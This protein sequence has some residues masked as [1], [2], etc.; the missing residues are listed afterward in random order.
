MKTKISKVFSC[1][2][3][4]LGVFV[5]L[6]L[7]AFMN[8]R[9][10]YKIGEFTR[11]YYLVD[12]SMGKA[13]RLLVGSIVRLLT[14]NP[15]S[16]WIKNFALTVFFV[17]IFF[18]A[19][20]IG[21]AIRKTDESLRT[22]VYIFAMFF[23]SGSF[24]MYNYSQFVGMLDIYMFIFAVLAAVCACNKYLRYLVPFLCV[25]GVFTHQTFAISYFPL[26][27][28]IVFYLMI[29]EEKKAGNIIVFAVTSAVTVAATLFCVLKAP[30][31]MTVT[32]EEAAE[33]I[34]Q[35]NKDVR[36][37]DMETLAFF[38]FNI[39]PEKVGLTPEQ[40][41]DASL[42]DF[43]KVMGGFITKN[44][45]TLKGVISILL[46]TVMMLSL[47]Y[48]VWIRCIKNTESKA[49]RFVYACFIMFTVFIPVCCIISTDY[50]RWVQAGMLTQFGL[51]F[52]MFA[53]KDEAFA[54]AMDEFKV[55]FSDK[56]LLLF[57]IYTAYAF[58]VQRN[59]GA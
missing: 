35:R 19:I 18:T 17:T 39:A 7:Q 22:Q 46:P 44:S 55:F 4:E 33:I 54:K 15:T 30:E 1:C 25:A 32:F 40:V 6:C 58:S 2:K 59:L 56:K 3:Y 28:L 10:F 42:W 14:D 13:S 38:L 45:V 11:L 36:L 5:L 21:K 34:M 37:D 50:I 53:R 9:E 57:A 43:I 29:T 16:E 24:T 48:A 20:L 49:K 47:F 12:Y 8:L 27:I 51:A 23:V 52:L 26:V 31:T 41:A